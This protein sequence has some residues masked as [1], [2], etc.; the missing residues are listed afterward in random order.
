M[1]ELKTLEFF[2]CTNSKSQIVKKQSQLR[3]SLLVQGKDFCRTVVND[4]Q[5]EQHADVIFLFS[6]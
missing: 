4:L 1:A 6:D 5:V 2:T 3:G